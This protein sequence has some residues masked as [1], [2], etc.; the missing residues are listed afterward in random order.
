MNLLRH[1]EE[2]CGKSKR[3][4][5]QWFWYIRIAS[6]GSPNSELSGINVIGFAFAGLMACWWHAHAGQPHHGI[7]LTVANGSKAKKYYD[8]H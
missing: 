5:F 8:L 1:Y 4:P 7:G 6:V 3:L 2:T